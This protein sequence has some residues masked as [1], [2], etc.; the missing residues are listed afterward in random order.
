MKGFLGFGKK[1][2][3]VK[4]NIHFELCNCKSEVLIL[5][6]DQEIGLMDCAIYES[7]ISIRHKMSWR[8]KIKYIWQVLINNKPYADQIVL[9]KTQIQKLKVFLDGCI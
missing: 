5:E 1:S 4:N 3:R 2:K 6:Y 9:D 7:G 8:Q